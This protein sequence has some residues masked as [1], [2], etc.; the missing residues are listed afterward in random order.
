VAP[1]A[2]GLLIIRLD[3]ARQFVV[4]D[5]TDVRAVDAHAEGVRRHRHVR[6]A[7]DEPVLRRGAFGVAHAAVILD[8]GDVFREQRLVDLLDALA[9]GAVDD[10]GAVFADER[11]DAPD[12]R[13]VESLAVVVARSAATARR[14]RLLG[15]DGRDVE[16]KVF[17]RE[18]GDEFRRIA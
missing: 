14:R 16:G 9:R 5:E 3:G 2:S 12:L 17:A 7:P 8:G 10:A 6:L 1:R 11:D 15:V 13:G 4:R 18:A